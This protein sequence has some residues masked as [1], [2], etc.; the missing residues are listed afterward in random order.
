MKS[1][2]S[3]PSCRGPRRARRARWGPRGASLSRG[4]RRLA[5]RGEEGSRK[6]KS[7]KKKKKLKL[8]KKVKKP[9]T[10]SLPL[11]ELA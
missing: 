1:F 2:L 6:K 9:E 10:T 5:P 8:K 11:E 7:S 4:R 3:F